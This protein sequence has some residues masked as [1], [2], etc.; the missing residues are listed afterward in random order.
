MEYEYLFQTDIVDCYSS[1]YTHSIAWALHDKEEVKKKLKEHSKTDKNLIGN[2][3]DY[4]LR[5]MSY[6]QTNG[7]PQ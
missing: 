6:G 1:I 4:S 3:I 7:I 2:I 5:S